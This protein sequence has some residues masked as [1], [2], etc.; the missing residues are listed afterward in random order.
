MHSN[1]TQKLPSTASKEQ[2]K[3]AV[4]SEIPSPIQKLLQTNSKADYA[5]RI[6]NCTILS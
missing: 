2:S 3:E 6:E 5:A 1:S 4:L